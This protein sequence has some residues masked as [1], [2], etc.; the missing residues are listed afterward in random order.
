MFTKSGIFMPADYGL[1]QGD[2]IDVVLVGSGGYGQ[3]GVTSILPGYGAGG[4]TSLGTY[5]IA[6]S[7]MGASGGFGWYMSAG[8]N[9]AYVISGGG[10]GGGYVPGAPFQG[11]PGAPAP[12][13]TGGMVVTLQGNGGGATQPG[14]VYNNTWYAQPSASMGG[15]GSCFGGGNATQGDSYAEGGAGYGGGGATTASSA[16]ASSNPANYIG[17]GGYAGQIVYYSHILTAEDVLNG[18]PVTVGAAAVYIK[19]GA[20]SAN[21]YTSD[22]TSKSLPVIGSGWSTQLGD[23]STYLRSHLQSAH[24]LEQYFKPN[25]TA[26]YGIQPFCSYKDGTVFLALNYV[27]S[28]NNNS[29]F[30]VSE[31][32]VYSGTTHSIFKFSQC[33]PGFSQP[34]SA[35]YYIYRIGDYF[36][37][38][39]SYSNSSTPASNYIMFRC[40]RVDKALSGT[41]TN[42]DLKDVK[43]LR[44]GSNTGSWSWG[45]DA[46]GGL[47]CITG[48]N[49]YAYWDNWTPDRDQATYVSRT[50]SANLWNYSNNTYQFI[51]YGTKGAVCCYFS[52]S[53]DNSSTTNALLTDAANGVQNTSTTVYAYG[54]CGVCEGT[55]YVYRMRRAHHNSYSYDAYGLSFVEI[56]DNPYINNSAAVTSNAYIM[57]A[58][59]WRSYTLY[60]AYCNKN[61]TNY[62]YVTGFMW[63]TID[64][65]WIVLTG[66]TSTSTSEPYNVSEAYRVGLVVMLKYALSGVAY[67]Y[68]NNGG[69]P[70]ML[71]NN[72]YGQ[73]GIAGGA[74]GCCQITW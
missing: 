19:S 13:T 56:T 52:N 67:G 23:F 20:Y 70:G 33:F 49:T 72:V 9:G 38:Y 24:L 35:P 68:N 26:A 71:I 25:N 65:G 55:N 1:S 22:N 66:A 3:W 54:L 4:D 36:V 45:F 34:H 10:G 48:Q 60:T 15:Q 39:N 37:Q 2:T 43:W 46:A 7:A 27:H 63:P 74:G 21:E 50:V 61:Q 11:G 59:Q 73:Q 5:A 58:G 62:G 40:I 14:Y 30:G 42:A 28:C 64:G 44:P 47:I 31:V 41:A 57:F 51:P 32:F 16:T 53:Y 12:K 18:I 8:V 29:G 69:M 6:K 17:C